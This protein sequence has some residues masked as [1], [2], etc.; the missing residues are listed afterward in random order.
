MGV[1]KATYN[2]GGP[3]LYHWCFPQRNPN[4]KNDQC[5]PRK[6]WR[7]SSVLGTRLFAAWCLLS[8][9]KS[10]HQMSGMGVNC[11]V[12]LEPK[13][14]W[15]IGLARG[16]IYRKPPITGFSGKCQW[17][18]GLNEPST[19]YIPHLRR[20]GRMWKDVEGCGRMWLDGCLMDRWS[21]TH[22]HAESWA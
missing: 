12:T 18:L 15:N 14:P 6:K 9:W 3:T 21:S 7:S 11:W 16:N 8:G 2:W 10:W 17:M 5:R 1:Y 13:P 20:C 19:T 22:S 4:L